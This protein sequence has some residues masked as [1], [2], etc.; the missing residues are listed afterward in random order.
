ME[1]G[2]TRQLPHRNQPRHS[3]QE[4][5]GRRTAGRQDSRH[6]WPE[7]H[8]QVDGDQLAGSR[9]SDHADGRSGLLTLCLGAQ[10]RAGQGR[11]QAEG[12]APD[13]DGDCQQSGTEKSLHQRHQERTLRLEDR[14]LRARLHADACRRQGIQVDAQLR[15]YRADVARWLHHPFALPRQDQG[16]L[17]QVAE[18]RQPDARR[19]F[20]WRDQERA[21]RL[22][23][24]RGHRRQT[25][26]PGPGLQYRAGV[27]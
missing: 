16:S 8:R 27:L 5:R 14:Q 23:Q 3:G 26:H 17:R 25:R 15:W 20:P 19:L 10:R 21:E 7:R 13:A 6:R 11:A 4:G 2:R 9:H 22:A 12:P 18:A 1:R 24:C